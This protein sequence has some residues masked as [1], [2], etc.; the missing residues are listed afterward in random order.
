MCVVL[1]VEDEIEFYEET[2]EYLA[3]YG[4]TSHHLASIVGLKDKLATLRPDLLVL[5]QF[6]VGRDTLSEISE[7]RPIYHGGIVVFTGNLNEVDRIVALECGA[8]DFISKQSSLREFVARL[9][10]VLRR[11]KF[12][13][14]VGVE[15][16]ASSVSVSQPVVSGGLWDFDSVRG[17]IRTPLGV[18]IKM[19]GTEFEFLRYMEAH[20]GQVLTRDQI[21]KDIFHRKYSADDRAVDNMLSRIRKLLHP[22]LSVENP[23]RSIRGSGY[24]FAGLNHGI[25]KATGAIARSPNGLDAESVG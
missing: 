22:H 4:I 13:Q 19:T 3:R 24:V 20:A 9:R 17:T 12:V 2:A 23:F 16:E 6:I 7:I 11:V 8:D 14:F 10:S 1:F 21:C 18:V 15:P 5:D 25:G